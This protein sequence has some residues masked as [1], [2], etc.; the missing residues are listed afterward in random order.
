MG[1]LSARTQQSRSRWSWVGLVGAIAGA[2]FAAG[3]AQAALPPS[4]TTSDATSITQTSAVLHGTLDTSGLP[5]VYAFAWG[6]ST[7]Y[8]QATPMQSVT[9]KQVVSATITG[10]SPGK[11]YH[12]EL[13]AAV[14]DPPGPP[15]SVTLTGGDKT[16][17]TA[18]STTPGFPGPGPGPG[19]K[20][21]TLKLLRKR[22]VVSG[23]TVRVPL[24]C[25]STHMCSGSLSITTLHAVGTILQ[26]VSCVSGKQFSIA[27][28]ARKK[29]KAR[30]QNGCFAL[31][32]SAAQHRRHGSLTTSLSTGQPNLSK[33]V[34]LALG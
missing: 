23:Q 22:L 32:Q 20:R 16:F 24:K 11:P 14:P 33:G 9:G 30:L 31:L 29:V 18:T 19:S 26:P 15:Y 17:T 28:G 6:T 8:G 5:A 1:P 25:A 12:F 13:V 34:T 10:L 7:G 27:A 21:G 2:I 4:A 3:S